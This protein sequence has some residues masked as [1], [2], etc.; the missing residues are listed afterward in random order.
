MML[1]ISLDLSLLKLKES[2]SICGYDPN[3]RDGSAGMMLLI[4]E[5][6]AGCLL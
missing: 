5:M 6:L 2:S 4:A 1:S 3:W